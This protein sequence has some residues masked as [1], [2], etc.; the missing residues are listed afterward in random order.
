MSGTGIAARNPT[1]PTMGSYNEAI[2]DDECNPEAAKKLLAAAGYPDGFTTDLWA[3]PVQCP[4]NPNAKR[5]AELTQA[6]LVKVGTKAE[7][8]SFE[9]GEYRKRM[10][11]GEHR[12][13]RLGW[14]GDNGDPDNFLYILLGCASAQSISG[15]NIAKFCYPPHEDGVRKAKA[16]TS[17][18]ECTRLTSRRGDF[19]GAG[20]LVHDGARGADQAGSQKCHRLQELAVR[21]ARFLRR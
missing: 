3:M 1:P 6:D 11:A 16:V 12:M 18:A 4:Y 7:I 17:L 5:I 15:S 19:Q 20:A 2:K 14:T 21:P 13:G 9:W 10:Q 8:K